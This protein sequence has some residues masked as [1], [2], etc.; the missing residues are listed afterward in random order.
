MKKRVAQRGGAATKR[1]NR[2]YSCNTANGTKFLLKKQEI[3]ILQCSNP[4]PSGI[5]LR[6]FL[7]SAIP[8]RFLLAPIRCKSLL[9]VQLQAQHRIRPGKSA[10]WKVTHYQK[11]IQTVPLPKF[12]TEVGSEA[13]S[14][15]SRRVPSIVSESCSHRPT[16]S[17]GSS[18]PH[19]PHCVCKRCHHT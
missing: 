11:Q 15:S 1:S 6:F 3:T 12:Q 2:S 17:L 9:V 14:S 5:T 19:F 13:V 8:E 4:A 16:G 18:H 10:S 7:S